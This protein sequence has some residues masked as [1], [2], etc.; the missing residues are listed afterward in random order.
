MFQI[1][2]LIINIICMKLVKKSIVYRDLMVEEEVRGMLEGRRG[3][4][5]LSGKKMS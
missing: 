5:L 3:D 1:L 2:I 4:T